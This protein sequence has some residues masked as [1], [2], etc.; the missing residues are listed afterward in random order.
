MNDDWEATPM[1][2]GDDDAPDPFA[3]WLRTRL[4]LG[5]CRFCGGPAASPTR[6]HCGPCLAVHQAYARAAYAWGAER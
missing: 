6:D 2:V 1:E 4:N 3:A 5:T